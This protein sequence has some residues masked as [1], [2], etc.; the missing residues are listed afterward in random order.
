MEIDLKMAN[1]EINEIGNEIKKSLKGR[2]SPEKH[3]GFIGWI[4]N[5]VN[6]EGENRLYATLNIFQAS[7]QMMPSL[8]EI[9]LTDDKWK[10][11]LDCAKENIATSNTTKH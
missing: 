3:T 8:C 6:E 2:I 7:E 10:K 9:I 11:A 4:F 1:T 5:K